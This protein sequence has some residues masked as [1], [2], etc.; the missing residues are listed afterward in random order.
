M[1]APSTADGPLTIASFIPLVLLALFLWGWQ[2]TRRIHEL[3]VNA[4]REACA[5]QGLQLL[6]GT[7]VLHRYAW[8]R[9][10]AGHIT[11]QRTFLFGYS[12]DGL[13]RRTGFVITLG[14]RI[15]QVGL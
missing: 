3:A 12:E 1:P 11:L 15:E 2:N 14:S 9:A 7:V 6:D 8:K 5:R 10:A 4:A 13:E